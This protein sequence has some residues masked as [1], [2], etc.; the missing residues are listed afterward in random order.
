MK[1]SPFLNKTTCTKKTCYFNHI[2]VKYNNNTASHA[3]MWAQHVQTSNVQIVIVYATVI[4]N[5]AIFFILTYQILVH[6]IIH[7]ID[8][9]VHCYFIATNI[10]KNI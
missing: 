4:S 5:N 3:A 2:Y 7:T 9:I 8:V 1:I 6:N 10:S